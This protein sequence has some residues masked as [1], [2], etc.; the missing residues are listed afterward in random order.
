VT[1][2]GLHVVGEIDAASV[3]ELELQLAEVLE[4]GVDELVLDFHGVTFL[5]SSGLRLLVDTANGLGSGVR[6][7]VRIVGA[8]SAVRRVFD[9]AGLTHVFRI[10][11]E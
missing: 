1:A 3:G 10:D 11:H 8:T 2:R 5:D 9:A 7:T 4:D 6:C